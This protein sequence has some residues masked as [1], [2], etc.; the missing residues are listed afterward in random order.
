MSESLKNVTG[1]IGTLSNISRAVYAD[2]VE[3]LMGGIAAP[4]LIATDP[5]V[6]DTSEFA[7]EKHLEDFLVQNWTQ[8]ELGKKFDIYEEGG[9]SVGQQYLTDTGPLDILAIS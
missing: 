1:A 8:T 2:E 6:D 7:M 9:E 4:S 3:K 5:A